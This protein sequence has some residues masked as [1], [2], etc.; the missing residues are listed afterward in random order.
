MDYESNDMS[1]YEE[2][3]LDMYDYKWDDVIQ[4]RGE[5]YYYKNYVQSVYKSDNKYIAKVKGSIDKP[6]TVNISLYEDDIDV[7]C[8]CPC[9]FPCKHEYA[10]M[11]AIANKEYEEVS[12]MKPI[13]ELDIDL[14]SLINAIPAEELKSYLLSPV[15]MDKVVF[16]TTAL[17]NYFRGYLPKQSYEYYY[18]NLYNN[19]LLNNEYEDTIKDY[20]SRVKQYISCN[21]YGE[22]FKIVKSIIEAYNGTDRLNYDDYFIDILPALGM[23]F[24][25][26]YRKA[27]E[28]IRNTILEY[29]HNLEN[30][31]YYDNVYLEDIILS[32]R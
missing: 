11:M 7:D 16:E 29:I 30:K 14:L 4:E 21:I 28:H 20:I 3:I 25:I 1:L 26:A 2:D 6:Y 24:R 15:G 27:D 8:T 22:V 19:I 10:V 17:N 12:L 32:I 18:N 5:D 31:N 9:D 13:K 23:Y